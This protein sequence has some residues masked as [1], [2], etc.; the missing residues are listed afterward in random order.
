[1]S[2]ENEKRERRFD[3]WWSAR[4]YRHIVG[5]H[6]D[7]EQARDDIK[8]GWMEADLMKEQG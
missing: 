2:T 6:C 1:M 3:A 4:G 7:Y 8:F 5:R